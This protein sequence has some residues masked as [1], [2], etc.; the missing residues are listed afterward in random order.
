MGSKI[1]QITDSSRVMGT[2]EGVTLLS[3]DCPIPRCSLLHG[4]QIPLDPPLK[5]EPEMSVEPVSQR[6]LAASDRRMWKC[7]VLCAF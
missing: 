5:L 1:W 4:L 7:A 2:L 3:V 6:I